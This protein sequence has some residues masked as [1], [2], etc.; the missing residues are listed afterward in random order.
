ML[1]ALLV[2]TTV[3]LW[4]LSPLGCGYEV[5]QTATR[6]PVATEVRETSCDEPL[7]ELPEPPAWAQG[8]LQES[9]LVST[10]YGAGQGPGLYIAAR[11]AYRV[12]LNGALI[13]E[14][15]APRT[16]DFIPLT[17]VP[18]D[19]ALVVAVWAARGTPTALMQLDDLTE[20]YL[21]DENWQVESSPRAGFAEPDYAP[22]ASEP[23]T[24]HG[25]LGTHPGCDPSAP[26]PQVS[27]ASWIGPRAGAGS[28]VVLRRSI[29]IAPVGFGEGAKG[30]GGASPSLVT[31]FEALEAA[32]ST[33]NDAAVIFIP[34]G[35]YDFR[36]KGAE[37]SSRSA[38]SSAC[39]EDPTK[40]QYRLLPTG[41]DCADTPVTITTDERTLHLGSNKTIVGL[42]RGALLRGVSLDFGARK[43][44][45]LR[46]VALY[47]VN[48]TL[49]EAGD[50]I[51]MT[52]ASDIWIDHVTTKWISDGLTDILESTRNVTLSW[53]HYD[54]AN[55]ADCRGRHTHAS[56]IRGAGVT[57]HHCFFDHVD[58]R[59]PAAEDEDTLVHIFNGLVQDD[60]SYGVGAACGAQVLLEG[61][62]FRRVLSPTSRRECEGSAKSLISAENGSNLYLQDVG[63]H[64][65]GDGREPNDEVFTP[66][67][68]YQLESADESWP[69]V[70]ERAGVGGPWRRT[71]SIEP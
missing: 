27:L 11:D 13:Y 33:P 46:N 2:S 5:A 43:N 44:I 3:M 38:C 48:R 32:A 65:G 64:I 70:L 24:E 47:D 53:M 52:G 34:E 31:T 1:R 61:T 59:A 54:G 9:P 50:A 28:N 10:S 58:S 6:D 29:R 67:Y 18:G 36:R 12:Y 45:V 39:T 23:V 42:G 41:V 69:R 62:A 68:D 17:L 40:A 71:L 21:S 60:E 25:R 57:L 37:V 35:D 7:E 49:Q 4:L 51:G 26:F 8:T 66:T 19:N 16:S 55:P 14:S 63:S 56:T 22:S 15:R 20:S 30:G